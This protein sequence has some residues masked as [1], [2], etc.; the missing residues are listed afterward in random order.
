LPWNGTLVLRNASALNVYFK[1][2]LDEKISVSIKIDSYE[3]VTEPEMSLGPFLYVI[4]SG[5]V[6]LVVI[7]AVIVGWIMCELTRA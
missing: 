6:F 7:V 5:A 2:P 1:N 3:L 4:V